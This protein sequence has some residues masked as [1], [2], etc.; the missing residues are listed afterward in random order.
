MAE[1]VS[2]AGKQQLVND[3]D[4][5]RV[6]TTTAEPVVKQTALPDNR[7]FR[8]HLDSAFQKYGPQLPNEILKI[9]YLEKYSK[10]D[11]E[12]Y[13]NDFAKKSEECVYGKMGD[14]I[15]FVQVTNWSEL[16]HSA[17]MK[18]TCNNE[19]ALTMKMIALTE[20]FPAP[21]HANGVDFKL[22]YLNLSNMM[23]GHPVQ[24][25]N[26]AT[27]KVLKDVYEATLS[28]L[29]Q[30]DSTENM[31]LLRQRLK[32]IISPRASSSESLENVDLPAYF[33]DS[34]LNPFQLDFEKLFYVSR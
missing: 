26:S 6:D 2:S 3:S 10:C 30:S 8:R 21:E 29:K 25:M 1:E 28:Q 24:E 19:L 12:R 9:N 13:V 5:N 27:S 31:V 23:L 14:C 22:L 33:A 20:Q 17:G 32:N 18:D 4:S 7:T 34:N 15:D 16:M 11:V